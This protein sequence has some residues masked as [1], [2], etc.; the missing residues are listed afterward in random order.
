MR[1][2]Y[3]RYD[4]NESDNR[5]FQRACFMRRVAQHHLQENKLTTTSI[6]LLTK[7]FLIEFFNRLISDLIYKVLKSEERK[8]GSHFFDPFSNVYV[9]V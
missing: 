3:D 2:C 7:K 4:I 8:S 9:A 6:Y 5:T 1:R